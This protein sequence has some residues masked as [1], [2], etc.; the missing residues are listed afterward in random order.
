METLENV[1]ATQ[2]TDKEIIVY[3]LVESKRLTARELAV[4]LQTSLSQIQRVHKRA[5]KKLKALQ[6]S[7]YVETYHSSSKQEG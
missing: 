4:I 7:G 3:R 1:L 6:E 5:K 2:L